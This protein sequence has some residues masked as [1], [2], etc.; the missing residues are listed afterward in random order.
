MHSQNRFNLVEERWIPIAGHGLASLSEIFSKNE[1]RSLGG[2]PIQKIALTKLLLAICQAAATPKDDEEW[3]EMGADG[4]AQKAL[5]YLGEKKD[6]FNLYGEKPFLQMPE[7]SKA[8]IQTFGAVMPD[9]S[10]GNTTVLTQTQVERQFSDE[11]RALI[12]IQLMSFALSGKKTDN[13]IV[14][15]AGYTGKANEK[16]KPGAGKAG[17][18]LAYMGLLHSHLQ[19]ENLLQSLW[20]N[21]LTQDH[22]RSLPMFKNG[23]GTP[24]WEKMPKGEA[25]TTAKELQ[26]SLLGRL[27][28]ISRF[29]LL[30]N[31]GLHYSEGIYY[32]SYKDGVVDPSAAVNYSGKDVK[33]LWSDPEK[34][35]WRSLVS[36]LSF[37]SSDN[38]GSYDCLN[39]KIGLNRA[40]LYTKTIGVW[41]GGLSVSSNAGEQYASGTDDFVE[42]EVLLE[43]GTL[44]ESWYEALKSQMRDL[45]ALSKN[46]YG[47]TMAFFKEQLVEGEKQA[48]KASNLFW[49][50]S[51][52]YFQKLIDACGDASKV[53]DLRKVFARIVHQCFDTYCPK[54]TVRQL[55]AW[56]KCRP[57]VGWYLRGETSKEKSGKS[58]SSKHKILNHFQKQVRI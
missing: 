20:L 54:D 9:V 23:L 38:Q 47:S 27:V 26:Y 10:T 48:A 15:S 40:R 56:A 30:T 31:N 52:A 2:N 57:N 43:S 3:A 42:S 35:P 39:I 37:M 41:S 32:P 25:C 11:E 7:I 51:E 22:L 28:P 44:G 18:S 6:C 13:S 14:L 1:F 53:A 46:I 5:K 45:D 34:R 36:L 8:A 21:I 49:Q 4:M 16:G 29:L 55:D 50:L 33:V 24:P 58:K 17:P 12:I 19:G